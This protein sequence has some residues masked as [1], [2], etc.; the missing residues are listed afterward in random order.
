MAR[1]MTAYGRA[2]GTAGGK[3]IT[4]ELKS[5]NSRFFDCTVKLPRQYGFLEDKIRTYLQQ[6]DISRGKVEVSLYIELLESEGVQVH[7]DGAY[8]EG[9]LAALYALRDRFHL[10]DDISVMSVAQ[11]RDLFIL[12]K[13]EED[14]ERDWAD[15]QTVLSGAVEA[16]LA[17]RAAEGDRL[18]ADLAEKK[19]RLVRLAGEIDAL[20]GR[21]AEAYRLRL[22]TRLRAVL[23]EYLPD[24][25]VDESRILTEC[26][27]FA[28]KTA[29][30]EEVVRLKSHF[31]A[32]D[33][34]IASDEPVGRK[35]DFLLQEMNREVNTI[36][37]K[38]SDSEIAQRVVAAKCI[39]EKLRE[40]VQNV[41]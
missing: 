14:T 19:A 28:D 36:G 39:I 16:F 40:Q 33:A 9:Y 3:S 17:M 27:I 8:A 12:E 22:E 15:V 25:A 5:V 18:G 29:I 20:Q 41:V 38:A 13:A 6:H 23:D 32:F 24:A 7:L 21:A 31:A 4:V 34:A 11:N 2:Q 30:D 35:M 1:S 10:T 26:A 37:S